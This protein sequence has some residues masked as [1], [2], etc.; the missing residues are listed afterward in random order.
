MTRGMQRIE[1]IGNVGRNPESRFTQSGKQVVNFSV[2]VNEKYK[3]T[4]TT[5]WFRC[6]AWEKLAEICHKYLRKGSTVYIAGKIKTG[7]YTDKD[8]TERQTWDV[9]VREINLLGPKVDE[10][11]VSDSGT[12]GPPV[13]DSFGDDDQIPF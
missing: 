10:S 3:E 13:D 9:V 6:T 8:G 7:K 1:F 12:Q 11:P 4:E 2:A 5:E